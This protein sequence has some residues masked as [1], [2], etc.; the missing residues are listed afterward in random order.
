MPTA[1]ISV[2]INRLVELAKG[3]TEQWAM[4]VSGGTAQAIRAT[5][6]IGSD[7]VEYTGSP[8]SWAGE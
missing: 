3:L 6:F 7:V 5:G 8:E 2:S 4:L 1:L